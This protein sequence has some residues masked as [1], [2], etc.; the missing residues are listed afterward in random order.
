MMIEKDKLMVAARNYYLANGIRAK[1]KE[2]IESIDKQIQELRERRDV[3]SD[4]YENGR[5]CN[6]EFDALLEASLAFGESV[7][8]LEQ[9]SN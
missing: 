5:F 2:Q 6:E 1:L 7:E 9:N 4:K 8:K 3:L